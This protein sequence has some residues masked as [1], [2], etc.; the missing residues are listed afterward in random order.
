VHVSITENR[1]EGHK[2]FTWRP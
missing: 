2:W 1:K